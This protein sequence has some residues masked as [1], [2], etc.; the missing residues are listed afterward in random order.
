MKVRVVQT[1]IN[2]I[3][4]RYVS[5]YLLSINVGLQFKIEVVTLIPWPVLP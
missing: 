3:Y 5:H 2:H 1:T 4:V